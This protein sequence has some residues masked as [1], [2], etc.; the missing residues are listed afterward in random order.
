TQGARRR[1]QA[2]DEVQG[3]PSQEAPAQK[4]T[5]PP[6]GP[7][8]GNGGR[9]RAGA[10]AGPAGGTQ[11]DDGPPPGSPGDAVAGRRRRGRGAGHLPGLLVRPQAP[12]QTGGGGEEQLRAVVGQDS[13]PEVNGVVRIGILTH[14]GP[15]PRPG[16]GVTMPVRTR[17]SPPWKGRL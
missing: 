8:A 3:H 14:N 12:P 5:A 17:S 2:E 13:D 15:C 16:A 6:A 4:E 9:C 10:A 7:A 1:A 11:G